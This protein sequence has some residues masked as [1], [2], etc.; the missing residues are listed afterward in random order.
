MVRLAGIRE[1]DSVLE[2]GP[3]P[4]ALTCTLLEAHSHVLAIEIDPHYANLL[5]TLFP[6]PH[7]EVLHTNFLDYSPP[8]EPIR[9]VVANIPYHISSPIVEKLA[10][11]HAAYSSIYLTVEKEFALRLLAKAP[12]RES[13][14]LSLCTS[15]LFTKRICFEIPPSCFYPRPKTPSVFLE[16]LPHNHFP[17]EDSR[18]FLP[19]LKTLFQK[20]R[21]SLH[22][23]LGAQGKFAKMRPE[24][25]SLEESLE[26]FLTHREMH[27]PLKG[28]TLKEGEERGKSYPSSNG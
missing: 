1:G 19:F 8:K 27:S 26:L 22:S 14:P 16:L 24:E 11:D 12:S 9:K 17:K 20:R 3:G 25:L 13:N 5:P 28:N 4:G 6:S 23:I 15:L 18:A 2:I 10:L 21:K 7:L